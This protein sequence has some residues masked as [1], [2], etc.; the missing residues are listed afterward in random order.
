MRR[1]N[2]TLAMAIHRRFGKAARNVLAHDRKHGQGFRA[3]LQGRRARRRVARNP[4]AH[5]TDQRLAA[6]AA[7]VRVDRCFKSSWEL[8]RFGLFKGLTHEEASAKLGAWVHRRQIN[9]MFEVRRVGAEE[10]LFLL[11]L[12]R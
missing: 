9:V 4:Q 5:R 3:C 2:P 11:L 12:A 6:L 8:L 10:V 1:R 7:A